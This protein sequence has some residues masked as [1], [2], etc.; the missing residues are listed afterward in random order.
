MGSIVTAIYRNELADT[1][2]A[3]VPPEAHKIAL[4]TLAGAVRVAEHLPRDLGSLLLGAARESFLQGLHVSIFISAGLAAASAV[5]VF[6][7]LR[8]VPSHQPN[9]Q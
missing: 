5:I 8:N 9:A 4:D 3:T 2:P 1:I 6:I 7:A